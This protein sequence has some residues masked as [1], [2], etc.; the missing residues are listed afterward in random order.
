MRESKR[1]FKEIANK[2]TVTITET[3]GKHGG[4]PHVTMALRRHSTEHHLL[5]LPIAAAPAG[6]S[7]NFLL[8]PPSHPLTLSLPLIQ[9]G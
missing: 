5:S 3:R 4:H 9:N 6:Y 8:I 7:L 1:R 2:E